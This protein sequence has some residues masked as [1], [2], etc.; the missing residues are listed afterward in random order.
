MVIKLSIPS[1]E[2][3]TLWARLS[4]VVS[5]RTPDEDLGPIVLLPTGTCN[6]EMV[7]DRYHGM[8]NVFR[9]VSRLSRRLDLEDST[10]VKC[11]IIVCGP[12]GETESP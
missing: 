6:C 10:R 1:D 8:I 9:R 3:L 7:V 5:D 2:E 4:K 11:K 12:T